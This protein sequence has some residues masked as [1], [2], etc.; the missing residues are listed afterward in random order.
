MGFEFT[1][2]DLHNCSVMRMKIN[3]PVKLPYA[4]V[5]NLYI[6]IPVRMNGIIGKIVDACF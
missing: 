6:D 1:P 5:N 4:S 2:R 3:T